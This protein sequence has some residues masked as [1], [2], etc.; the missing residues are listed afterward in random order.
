M[1]LFPIRPTAINESQQGLSVS[2]E[3]VLCFP[4]SCGNHQEEVAEGVH[5]DFHSWGTFH[6]RFVP[7]SS[8]F[9]AGQA[10]AFWFS[11]SADRT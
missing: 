2:V 3:S 4:T 8:W 11:N 6:R 9:P 1:V 7:S 10:V 5:I